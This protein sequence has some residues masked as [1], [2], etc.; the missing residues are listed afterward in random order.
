MRG[1][2]ISGSAT[3]RRTRRLVFLT[4]AVGALAVPSVAQAAPNACFTQSPAPAVTGQVVTFDSSCST[5]VRARGWEFDK[6]STQYN[7]GNGVTATRTYALPGS[8]DVKLGVVD[9]QGNYDFETKTITIAANTAPVANFSI[10]PASPQTLEN[11]TFTSSST[12]ANGPIAGQSWDTDNDGT[13]DD[14]TG[15]SAT[16]Q[17]A[18]SGT[19]TVRLRVVD[20]SGAATIA[21]KTVTAANRPPTSSFTVGPASPSSGDT[22]TFTSTVGDQDGTVASRTWDLDNDGQFDDGTAATVTHVFSTPGTKTV[23]LRVVDDKGASQTSTRTVTVANRLPTTSF[24]ISPA[25]PLTN[26]TV[27]FTSTSSD[28]DG[29]IARQEWDLDNDGQYDD[30]TATSVTRSFALPGTYTIKFRLVD[31]SGGPGTATKTVTVANRPPVAAFGFTPTAPVA[32]TPVQVGSTATDPDGTVASQAWDL[33][34][35]GQYDDATGATAAFTPAAPGSYP[36]ALRV[37]DDRGATAVASHTIVVGALPAAQLPQ[38]NVDQAP[39]DSTGPVVVPLPDPVESPV[40]PVSPLRWLDPFPVVRIR[41]LSTRKGARLTL[42]SVTA[43][44]G[45]LV[46]LRCLGSSCPTRKP[47]RAT[48][49]ARSGKATGVVRFKRMERYL[50]AGTKIRIAITQDGM[51]GKYTRFT[52]RRLAGPS[53]SDQCVVPG[54]TRPVKCPVAP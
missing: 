41:G 34:G 38:P 50:P 54:S 42:L 30:G 2:T 45:S 31:N 6:N 17:F 18:T 5:G 3:R 20:N 48:I 53:R 1:Y 28:P 33:D 24:S 37:T 51:V 10:A 19:Y 29:T 9:N 14:G 22:V 43:P 12:D 26:Q 8:Y 25:Q 46:D 16:R 40:N 44:G 52:I 35:D 11:V 49:K 47:Q 15:T 36:V 21:S 13:F 32:G 27:T 39:F 7:D 23:S 4:L